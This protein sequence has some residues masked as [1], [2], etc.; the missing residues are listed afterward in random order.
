MKVQLVDDVPVVALKV[1]SAAERRI[2]YETHVTY[3]DSLL[4]TEKLVAGKLGPPVRSP[5]E[6]VFVSFDEDFARWTDVKVGDKVMIDVQG[7]SMATVVGSIRHL[8]PGPLRAQIVFP[9]GVLEE[10]PQFHIVTA[11]LASPAASARFQRA[12]VQQFPGILVVDLALVLNVLQDILGKI[13]SVI[14]F[15]AGFSMLTGLIV[16][17]ASVLISKFQRIQESVLLRTLGASRR[18]VLVITMLEYFFIGAL[19]SV[20]GIGLS[21]GFSLA[22]A[23]LIFEA[24]F[25]PNWWVVAGLFVGIS[26]LTVLIGLYNVRGVL[27]RPPLEVMRREG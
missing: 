4:R 20:V 16:L 10:A 2:D 8:D 19:A 17:I 6:V 26:S 14:R 22:L 12:V 1:T 25:V 21:M 13:G 11:M 15:M 24:V 7:V 23:K 5:G 9:T 18:Q 3:R 27:N